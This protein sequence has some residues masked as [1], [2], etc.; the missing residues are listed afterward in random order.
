MVMA[1]EAPNTARQKGYI[2]IG[3]QE[4]S[5]SVGISW[6]RLLLRGPGGREVGGGLPP[7]PP[8]GGGGVRFAFQANSHS[9][10]PPPVPRPRRSALI[11][12][13]IWWG[14]G[15]SALKVMWYLGVAGLRFTDEV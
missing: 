10:P 4:V 6:I 11:G 9:N 2:S 8:S 14:F 5:V 15:T 12:S 3:Q 1:V 13:W 7:P